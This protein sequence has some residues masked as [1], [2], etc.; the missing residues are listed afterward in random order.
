M[1]SGK[2]LGEFSFKLTSLTFTPGPASSVLVQVNCEGPATGYGTVAGTLT[3][4][5]GK[6]G[7]FSWC[8]AAYLDNGDQLSGTG[9]G[10]FE[11]SGKHRWRTRGFVDVSDGQTVATEGEMDLATRSWNGK[12]FEKV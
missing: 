11:S 5:A 6:S 4:V 3:A 12:I 7:T 9:S 10:T 1:A 2:Q 8:A